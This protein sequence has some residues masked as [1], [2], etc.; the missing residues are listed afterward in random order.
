[1]VCRSPTGVH[2]LGRRID[3]ED[4]AFGADKGSYS[5]SG[6]S[7]PGSNIQNCVPAA[8]Q[9]ALDQ[10]LRDRRKHLPDDFAV[11]L[12]ER[13]GSTPCADNFLIGLHHSKYS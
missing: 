2:H 12:P 7:G 3:P 4:L 1:M 13:R 8:N 6:L 11:L 5:Q 10:S 9:P